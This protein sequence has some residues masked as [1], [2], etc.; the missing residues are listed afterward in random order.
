MRAH[1]FTDPALAKHAGRF[2]WLAIDVETAKNQAFLAKYPWEAVPTFLV[3]DPATGRVAYKWLG[4]ADTEQLITRLAEG[5]TAVRGVAADEPSRRLAEAD[6]LFGQGKNAAAAAAYA[7]AAQA[8]GTSWPHRAR[9]IEN[10]V[11]SLALAG[12]ADDARRCAERALSEAPRLPRDVRFA[13]IVATGLGCALDAPAGDPAAAPWRASAVKALEALVNEA[14]A[15]PNL[16]GDDRS[17]LFDT[18]VRARREQGDDAGAKA[19]AV[20]WCEFIAQATAQAPT[21]EARAAYDSHRVSSALASGEPARALAGLEASAREL[22]KDY[23]PPARLAIIL[24]ELGRYDEALAASD[25]AL[26]LVYGPRKLTLF[27]ARAGIFEK[28]GDKAGVR[29]TLEDA[30]AFAK[31]LPPGPRTSGAI[32]RL[33]KRLA[34]S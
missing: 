11:L 31:T 2:A 7:D 20:R 13:S 10:E 26:S 9:A 34:A 3:I 8:G 25:R 30:L 1:V 18:L 19:L 12:G 16:L 14:V 6:V 24:R 27:D 29:R 17:S 28:K 21:P 23:N 4:T 5:E 33:E 22:P 15:L 32:A